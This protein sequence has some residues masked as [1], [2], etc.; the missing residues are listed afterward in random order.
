[1]PDFLKRR[2]DIEVWTTSPGIFYAGWSV[3]PRIDRIWDMPNADTMLVPSIRSF[4]LEYLAKSKVSVDPFARNCRLATY[5]NDLSQDTS[6]DH[7]MEAADFLRMLL[8]DGVLADL[9]IFDPP[10]SVRQIQEVYRGF[11]KENF[12][13]QECAQ[14]GRWNTEKDLIAQLLAPGGVCL[15]YGWHSNGMGLARRF[16]IERILLVAHGGAHNDTICVAE[17]RLADDAQL[18]QEVA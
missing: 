7:H 15:H 1:M 4:T 9:V 10:Y 17:R 18:F 14:L 13:F 11:G 2:R 12:T 5:T 16:A 3:K 6:A 8:S